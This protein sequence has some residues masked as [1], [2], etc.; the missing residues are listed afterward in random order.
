MMLDL[1][2]LAALPFNQL[3]YYLPLLV[4]ISLVYGATRHELP[5]PI[6]RHAWHTAV[7]MTTF[8]GAIFLIALVLTWLV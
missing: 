3:W 5:G 1:P 2:L 4:A 6:L 8:I 7:W